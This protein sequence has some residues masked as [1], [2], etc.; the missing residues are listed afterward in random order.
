MVL[1]ADGEALHAYWDGL[2][3]SRKMSCEVVTAL[4]AS[5]VTVEHLV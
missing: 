4:K 2:L 1:R 3:V 5:R